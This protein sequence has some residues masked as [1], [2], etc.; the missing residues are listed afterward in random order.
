DS[1]AKL[2]APDVTDVVGLTEQ[3]IE[4]ELI[5]LPSRRV[6]HYGDWETQENNLD[7]LCQRNVTHRC[8]AEILSQTKVNYDRYYNYGFIMDYTV[9]KY[10]LPDDMKEFYYRIG[11]SGLR[12]TYLCGEGSQYTQK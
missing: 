5:S 10:Q 3:E 9:P 11:K 8:G 7:F 6:Y 2:Y 1:F 4:S 12:L